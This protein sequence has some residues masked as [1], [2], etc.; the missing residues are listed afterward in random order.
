MNLKSCVHG[1]LHFTIIHISPYRHSVQ[2]FFSHCTFSVSLVSETLNALDHWYVVWFVI[3]I[4]FSI[5]MSYHLSFFSTQSMKLIFLL[6]NYV[7][8]NKG[9]NTDS[10]VLDNTKM[11]HPKKKTLPYWTETA[12]IY[13]FWWVIWIITPVKLNN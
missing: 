3:I 13:L 10:V 9:G 6:R 1:R 2:D 11:N 5:F 7:Q 8:P 4:I 12:R